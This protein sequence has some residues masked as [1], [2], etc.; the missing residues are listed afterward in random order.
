ML[1]VVYAGREKLI[2][3]DGWS[4]FVWKTKR[5]RVAGRRVEFFSLARQAWVQS[6]ILTTS[7]PKGR[8]A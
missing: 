6:M 7:A 4:S 2:V 5:Y 3:P 8:A 1:R